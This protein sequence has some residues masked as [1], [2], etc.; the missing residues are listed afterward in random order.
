MDLSLR[1]REVATRPLLKVD[2]IKRNANYIILRVER[3]FAPQFGP[4]VMF[5]LRD[6]DGFT[7]R[8]VL[9]PEYGR[10]FTDN[11]IKQI[12]KDEMWMEFIVVGIV[13][14]CFVLDIS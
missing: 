14:S 7:P 13:G 5:T 9:P 4:S 12:N 3:V 6:P 1:I 8:V 2:E 10:V 11:D